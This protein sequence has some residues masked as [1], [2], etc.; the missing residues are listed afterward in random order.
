MCEYIGFL[1]AG[2]P[3]RV[4]SPEIQDRQCK[5]RNPPEGPT[6]LSVPQWLSRSSA[7]A[8]CCNRVPTPS[9]RNEELSCEAPSFV[10][11][12]VSKICIIKGPYKSNNSASSRTI[13]HVVQAAPYYLDLSTKSPPEDLRLLGWLTHDMSCNEIQQ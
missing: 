7:A 9:R 10:S 13:P 11:H 12:T 8:S 5:L 6:C 4:V 1:R 2:L 3:T